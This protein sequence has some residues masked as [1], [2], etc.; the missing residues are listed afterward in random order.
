MISHRHKEYTT[1]EEFL[2]YSQHITLVP[3]TESK[4]LISYSKKKASTTQTQNFCMKVVMLAQLEHPE[5]RKMS[6][7]CVLSKERLTGW[8]YWEVTWSGTVAVAVTNTNR[9]PVYGFGNDNTSWALYSIR[10]KF[11]FRHDNIRTHISTCQSSTIGVYLDHSAGTLSF[12]SVSDDMTLLH[13]VQATFTQPLYAGFF[14][15]YGL[16]VVELK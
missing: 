7:F 5:R 11:E 10:D 1:R 6:H 9:L 12:Y 13:R 2:K 8:C 3:N 14:V 16:S 4:I 15:G